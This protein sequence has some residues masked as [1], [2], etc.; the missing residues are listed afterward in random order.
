M[1]NAQIEVT[2]G[3]LVTPCT[4]LAQTLSGNK[5][6]DADAGRIGALLALVFLGH[7][8]WQMVRLAPDREGRAL[9]VFKSNVWLGVVLVSLLFI[10]ALI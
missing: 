8:I 2:V 9:G 5:H 10:S 7:S 3:C 1:N 6:V 4:Y